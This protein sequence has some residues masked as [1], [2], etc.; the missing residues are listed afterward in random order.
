MGPKL[1]ETW[2]LSRNYLFNKYLLQSV[3]RMLGWRKAF[4]ETYFLLHYC[5]SP[6]LSGNTWQEL[7]LEPEPKLWTKVE[8]EINNFGSATL[9]W[10]V[11]ISYSSMLSNR[12]RAIS[13]AAKN[14]LRLRIRLLLL[15]KFHNKSTGT[16]FNFG[17][18]S[19]TV[20]RSRNYFF[21]APASTLTIISAPAPAPATAIYW[22][23]KLF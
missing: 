6:V 12:S 11:I 3:L 2:S 19:Y 23:F 7:E 17:H 14:L 1:F 21:S 18:F 8:P 13:A 9:L 10:Y 4:I 15:T 16:V 22:H 20:L 5:Y